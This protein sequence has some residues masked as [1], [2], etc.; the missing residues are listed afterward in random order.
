MK[1]WLLN[2]KKK[3]MMMMTKTLSMA[4]IYYLHQI[5]LFVISI[6]G[7]TNNAAFEANA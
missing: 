2:K 1:K 5:S 4:I 6:F 3:K 7:D